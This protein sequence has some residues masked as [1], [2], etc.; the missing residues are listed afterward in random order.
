MVLS[1]SIDL[2]TEKMSS[3]GN[4]LTT[5]IQVADRFQKGT[6]ALGLSYEGAVRQF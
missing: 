1:K 4:S 2:L 3:L 6:T 5:A